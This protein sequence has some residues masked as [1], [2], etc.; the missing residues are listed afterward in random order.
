MPK[1][2]PLSLLPQ[3]HDRMMGDAT[4]WLATTRPD[5]RPHVAP[6][7]FIWYADKPYIMTGGVKLANILRNG[8]AALNTENGVDV[9]I[10]EGSAQVV[11]RGDA[12]FRTVNEL[13]KTK[14]GWDI[15]TCG[16][17]QALIEITPKKAL[18]WKA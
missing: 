8:L 2:N 6:I 14:Y 15:T 13:F 3:V 18:K 9:A 4:A 12:V 16:D 10:V 7:W 11:P 17:D 5:G 1:R